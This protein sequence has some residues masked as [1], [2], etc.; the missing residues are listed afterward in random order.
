MGLPFAYSCG[1]F[2]SLLRFLLLAVVLYGWG[3]FV[4]SVG[5]SLL[6]IIIV[7]MGCLFAEKKRRKIPY[8]L[9]YLLPCLLP[10]LLPCSV[11]VLFHLADNKK[12]GLLWVVLFCCVGL[13]CFVSPSLIRKDCQ[14]LLPFVCYCY[15]LVGVVLLHIACRI[16]CNIEKVCSIVGLCPALAIVYI[17][18]FHL[19]CLLWVVVSPLLLF[20]K[21][22]PIRFG[23]LQHSCR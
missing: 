21:G 20:A 10:Y 13:L 5:F 7:F 1:L 19:V 22:L 18:A 6:V 2:S 16:A 23:L 15:C 12:H 8:L 17:C 11:S 4:A 14:N 9:P 3:C